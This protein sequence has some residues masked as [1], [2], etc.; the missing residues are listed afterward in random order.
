MARRGLMEDEPA[1]PASKQLTLFAAG[2]PASPTP[3][4]A[5]AKALRTSATSGPSL[6]DSFASLDPGG[7]WRKTSAGYCQ[8]MLDGSSEMFSETWPRAGCLQNG[9]AY[10]QVPSAPLTAATA[11]GLVA[12]PAGAGWGQEPAWSGPSSSRRSEEA[13]RLQLGRLGGEVADAL[14]GGREERALPEGEQRHALSDAVGRGGAGAD[15]ALAAGPRWDGTR[16]IFADTSSGAGAFG[17][18]ARSDWWAVEPDVGRVAH[19]VPARVDRL[20]G[21]GNSIVPQIAEWLGRRI[22]EADALRTA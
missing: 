4:L 21:L 6:R 18:L 17:E 13:R 22:R 2:F 12:Y 1:P 10:L 11:S 7:C 19:G 15:V 9:I 16:S 3:L 14:R 8:L 20:R 5:D